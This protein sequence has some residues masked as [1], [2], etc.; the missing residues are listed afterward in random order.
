MVKK[1]GPRLRELASVARG[2]QDATQGPP[3]LPFLYMATIS[4]N[5]LQDFLPNLYLP[6]LTCYSRPR[7]YGPLMSGQP[8]YMVNLARSRLVIFLVKNP[9]LRTKSKTSLIWSFFFG[10]N[11]GPYQR[12]R[13]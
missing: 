6:A 12:V 9:V 3:F 13:L 11:R 8:A 10:Q 7:L 5:F 1:V 4:A 2:S